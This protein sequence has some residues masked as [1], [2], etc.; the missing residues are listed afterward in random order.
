[1]IKTAILATAAILAATPVAAAPKDDTVSTK[2]VFADLDLT[3]AKGQKVLA[4]RIKIASEELCAEPRGIFAQHGKQEYRAC[5]AGVIE[6][7]NAKLTALGVQKA[8]TVA[9]R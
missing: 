6:Q 5:K 2:V 9:L 4:K 7:A 1:M 3:S 8:A